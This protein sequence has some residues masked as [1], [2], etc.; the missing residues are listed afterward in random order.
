MVVLLAESARGVQWIV[1]HNSQRSRRIDRHR[2]HVDP[3]YAEDVRDAAERTG[4]VRQLHRNLLLYRHRGTVFVAP[5]KS[6]TCLPARI[7]ADGYP[8]NAGDDSACQ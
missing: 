3:L 6:K 1:D 2:E 4:A 5:P 8:K 7:C